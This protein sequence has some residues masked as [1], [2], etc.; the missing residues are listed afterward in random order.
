MNEYVN[1]D[2]NENVS[3]NEYWNRIKGKPSGLF[4]QLG[5][6]PNYVDAGKIQQMENKRKLEE[7]RERVEERRIEKLKMPD[8][9]PSAARKFFGN[10]GS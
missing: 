3:N 1:N 5:L 4:K 2:E 6:N 9:V 7:M 8:H 10:C